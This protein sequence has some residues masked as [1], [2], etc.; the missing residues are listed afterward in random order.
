MIENLLNKL[1]ISAF[2]EVL[3]TSDGPQFVIKTREGGLLIGENG[4]NLISFNHIVK[5]ITSRKFGAEGDGFS[6]SLDIN[7]YQTK[8]IE[9]LRNVARINAQRVRYFKK[10]I[11][12]QPM[13]PFERRIIHV[14]L[15]DCPDIIT[16]S[17]GADLQ[18][19][20]IIKPYL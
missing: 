19:Q 7:N 14:T 1:T 20:V 3:E 8:K 16:E 2:V 17:K 12:L 10:E 9:N 6:F 18:R 11:A 4:K 13:N 15:E 5:K